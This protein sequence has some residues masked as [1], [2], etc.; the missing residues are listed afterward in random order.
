ME[1]LET[2]CGRKDYSELKND[3]VARSKSVAE[4]IKAKM[5]DL[6]YTKAD[7]LEVSSPQFKLLLSVRT[8]DSCDYL[9]C[10]ET[11]QTGFGYN[12]TYKTTWFAFE[13]TEEVE[14]AKFKPADNRMRIALLNLTS[15]I[16]KKLSKEE[17]N[18]IKQVKMGLDA[19]E[20]TKLTL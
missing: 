6:D 8:Y 14:G 19:T 20:S 12:E 4:L 1:N 9:C 18:R 7:K 5:K 15:E 2:V 10:E 16:A 3:L 17:D 13:V 11:V